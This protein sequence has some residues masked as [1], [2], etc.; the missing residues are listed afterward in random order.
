MTPAWPPGQHPL[1][2]RSALRGAAGLAALA[3]LGGLGAACGNNGRSSGSS[4]LAQWYHE[5][6]EKG[7]EQAAKRYAAAYKKAT[8]NVSWILGD[9]GTKLSTGLLGANGPDCFESQLNVS[10][11]QSKQVAPLDDLIDPVK[12]DYNS[13][14]LAPNTING[15]IYGVREIDDPQFFYY[16][17]SLFAKAKVSAPTT[18]DEL[19]AAAKALTTGSVKGVYAGQPGAAAGSSALS[20][21]PG[22]ALY[23]SGHSYLNA[24]HTDVDYDN[25]DFAAAMTALR[26]MYKDGSSLEGAPSDWTNPDSFLSGLCA[27]QWCGL[28]AMPQILAKFGD[29]VGVFPFPK[30]AASGK[31]AVYSGGWT[32]FVSAKSKRVDAAKAFTK[33]LWIDQPKYEEDWALSYGFHIPPRK[34]LAAKATK[35]HTGVAAEVVQLN[36]RYGF[37][38]DPY[39]TPK[40]ILPFTDMVTNVIQKGQDAKQQLAAAA[41]KSRAALRAQNQNG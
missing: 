27:A 14:D 23:A 12:S 5:Y 4:S 25:D 16:R 10:M 33:W 30:A 1:S 32:A 11:V 7:T 29:D 9:Y 8:V 39:W 20:A 28:W 6:G 38:D 17:K 19:V 3:G 26:T 21:I 13:Y 18:L 40:V 22:P 2:R 37:G 41:T 31:P 36:Q 35:L 15:H 24:D 34:S